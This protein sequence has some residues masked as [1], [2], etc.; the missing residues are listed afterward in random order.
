MIKSIFLEIGIQQVLLQL[1]YYSSN[2]FYVFFSFVLSIYKDIIKVHN[3][4][5]VKL[6]CKYLIDIILKCG[7]GIG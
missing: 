6:L 5:N 1:I 4:K 7:W 2:G 3:Y